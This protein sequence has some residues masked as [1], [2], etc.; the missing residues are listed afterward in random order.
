[1]AKVDEVEGRAVAHRL[2]TQTALLVY[3]NTFR[4][5]CLGWTRHVMVCVELCLHSL[6]AVDSSA[7]VRLVRSRAPPQ[8]EAPPD[9][10]VQ[11]IR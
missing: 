2:G 8:L 1:M 6:P 7:R 5:E 3:R 9:G 4:I 10:E 11:K